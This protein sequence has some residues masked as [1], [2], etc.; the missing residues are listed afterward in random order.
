MF[1]VFNK[2]FTGINFKS[3]SKQHGSAEINMTGVPQGSTL[4]HY[5]F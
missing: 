4:E 2:L 5:Y 3:S 1:T